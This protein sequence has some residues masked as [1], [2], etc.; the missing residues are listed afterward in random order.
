MRVG[1]GGPRKRLGRGWV[2]GWV[3]GREKETERR[4]HARARVKA[5]KLELLPA[6]CR[7]LAGLPSQPSAV[8][9][10]LLNPPAGPAG[11]PRTGGTCRGRRR[12]PAGL[13]TSEKS[14]IRVGGSDD[15]TRFGACARGLA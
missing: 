4:Q 9:Q 10:P 14:Q 11:G 5:V 7:L 13:A 6:N 15:R 8:I 1:A 3:G 2:G 12:N